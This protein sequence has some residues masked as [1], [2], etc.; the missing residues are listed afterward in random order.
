MRAR[1]IKLD[2]YLKERKSLV[3]AALE[4]YLP[5][6]GEAPA[7]VHEAMRY[8]TL[9]GGKRIRPIL[10]LAACETVGGSVEIAMP[11]ACAIELIHSFSLV[12]D[13]LPCMDN[14][15]FRR[16]RPTAHRAFGEAM[17]LLAGDALFALAFRLISLT[18]VE[19]PAN[20]VLDVIRLIASAAGT[21]G[22]VGGQVMDLLAQGRAV[23][24]S[25]VEQI[26]RLKTGALLEAS[27]VAGGMLGGGTEAQVGALSAYGRNVGL[28]F[29]IAD[30]ILDLRGDAAKLGKPVGSD[31]KLAKATYPS[32]IGIER[33]VELAARAVSD[34]ID[35][36]SGFDERAEPLRLVARFSVERE[37]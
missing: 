1:T 34:A 17:A 8:S 13:D 18:P 32:V 14:D 20:V 36:I 28:A 9:D 5:P 22:M 2:E 33:S 7:R 12:H 23:E 26:H 27:A 21:R 3:D 37:T 29:Q 31:L 4:Q 30:D 15:D 6:A 11:T 24:L 10:T 16:G 19:A 35:A 25:E